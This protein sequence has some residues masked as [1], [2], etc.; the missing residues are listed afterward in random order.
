MV[1]PKEKKLRAARL[2]DFVRSLMDDYDEMPF[3]PI[4]KNRANLNGT[5]ITSPFDIYTDVRKREI[6]VVNVMLHD[7]QVK[8]IV[9]AERLEDRL[10]SGRYGRRY[11]EYC[12]RLRSLQ[13]G[14]DGR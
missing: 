7:Q 10:K 3:I 13:F 8:F 14:V 2:R 9:D 1:G 12:K 6:L 11:N 4:T 5:F